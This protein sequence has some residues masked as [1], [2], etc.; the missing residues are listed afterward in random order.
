MTAMWWRRGGFT[1]IELLVVIAIMAGVIA[2]AAPRLLPVLLYSTHEGAARRLTNYGTAA[3]AEAALRHEKLTFKFDFA[4][5]EYWVDS[6]P[7]A[8][9]EQDPSN[10]A[11]GDTTKDKDGFPKDDAALEQMAAA[12]LVK[13]NPSGKRTEAGSKL[14]DEQARRMY[15]ASWK[16]QRS[17]IGARA[18]HV[19]QDERVLPRSQQKGTTTTGLGANASAQ[20]GV[21]L[22]KI[23]F[24]ARSL[25]FSTIT[26]M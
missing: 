10:T 13:Q 14:L 19:K 11:F 2:M 17:V 5:Q 21:G 7:K 1:L 23:T 3:I 6:L 22:E 16:R 9:D 15:V 8:S 4:T 12:E 26:P 20:N 25:I 24:T 18:D